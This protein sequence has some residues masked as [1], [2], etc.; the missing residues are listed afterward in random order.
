MEKK[1]RF[2]KREPSL[3]S[4]PH[5][6]PIKALLIEDDPEDAQLLRE[7]LAAAKGIRFHVEWV[8]RLQAG[9]ERLSHGGI[10][11]LLLD[12]SLPDSAGIDT[13][14]TVHSRA[15]G[16]PIVVLTGLDDEAFA[17]RAVRKGAQD[18]LVKGQVDSNLLARSIRYAIERKR[19]EEALRESEERFRQLA[20]NIHEVF[21]MSD[22]EKNEMIYVSLAYEEIWGCSCKSLYRKPRSFVDSI[23]PEDRGAVIATFQKQAQGKP[24]AVEYR[25]MRPDGS[26]RWI[27]SRG[28]PVRNEFGKA[29][30]VA[31]LAEDITERK[32]AEE[33]LKESEGKYRTIFE[34][35]GNATIIIEEDTTISLVNAEFE[36][37]I[38]YSK[39]EI[40]GKKNWEEFVMKY[41]IERL[42]QFHDARRINPDSAPRNHELK[43]IDR[44]GNVRDVFLTVAMIPGTG[45]SVASAL[46]IT[47]RKRMEGEL[48]KYTNDLENM[49]SERTSE[50]ANTTAF[51]NNI[52]ESSTEY[53]IVAT[54]LNGTILNWNTGAKNIFGYEAGEVVGKAKVDIFHGKNIRRGKGKRNP[55]GPPIDA[56][57]NNVNSGTLEFVRKNGE[58]FPA[59]L[60]ITHLRD[61]QGAEIGVL[62][63]IK[64]ITQRKMLERQL[65]QSEKMA[66]IGT[67]AAGIAH[68]IRNPLSIINTST[69]LLGEEITE[70]TSG[71]GGLLDQIRG[72]IR[73][74]E[75]II[76]NLLDF[77]RPAIHELEFVDL[78]SLMEQILSLEGRALSTK[79]IELR[80]QV[81]NVPKIMANLDSL[82]RIFL[83]LLINAVQSM[84][85]GGTLDIKTYQEDKKVTVEISDTGMGIAQNDLPRIF[86]PFF[87]TKEPGQGTGLGL[88]FVHSEI[89]RMGATIR[90]ETRAKKGSTFIV[91]F[92]LREPE[93]A[94]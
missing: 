76:N 6:S 71:I 13:V 38:G 84:P 65:L 72:G 25:I 24:I 28:F 14:L 79:N 78:K 51:L 85:R 33:A 43:I 7:I 59:D 49:V 27:R 64:D 10:D 77:S 55:F 93:N 74:A 56:Q 4:A 62:Y 31:G 32:L 82:R 23:H 50:L 16:V 89:D 73:R 47:E 39:D 18:Y 87:T 45:K 88:A 12:L 8:D 37:L 80:S 19:A 2:Q 26:V 52:L 54:D 30:R 92:P 46:D 63:V 94:G 66:G 5:P 61:A 22:L 21:W 67:L 15:S 69:Y 42:K 9:L 11:V 35:T 86:D 75:S 36:K 70:K 34:N 17:M 53:A 3:G 58:S 29:Y 44:E 40:E 68:E 60:T 90:V 81:K 91:Q 48:R 20:E 83:N 57:T 41:D 1:K